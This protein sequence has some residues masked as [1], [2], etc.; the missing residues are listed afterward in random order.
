MKM[1]KLAAGALL[2]I[3]CAGCLSAPFQPPA[4][5]VTAYSAPLTTECNVKQGSKTGS[6]EAISILGL[7]A[8]GDC[9]LNAA[10]KEGKLKE[11]YYADYKYLSILGIFQKVTVNVVGE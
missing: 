1:K 11:A 7:I 4:G 5:A 3:G 10:I 9:S 2:A 6:A 8:V